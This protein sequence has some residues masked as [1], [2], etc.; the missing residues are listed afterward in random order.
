MHEEIAG[1]MKAKGLSTTSVINN[2]DPK[3]LI[4]ETASDME[5]DCIF[6]GAR[7]L[8]KFERTLLGSVSAAISARAHCSVEV[9]RRRREK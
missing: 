3:Y 4:L 2:I 9:V 6:M 7:G 1:K 8:T 5:V